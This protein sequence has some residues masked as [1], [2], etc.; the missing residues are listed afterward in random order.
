MPSTFL[1]PGSLS[2]MY[3]FLFISCFFKSHSDSNYLFPLGESGGGENMILKSYV[4]LGN[5]DPERQ[6]S[7]VLF[8]TK[9]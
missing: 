4:E 3:H 5:T 7:H 6:L 1:E 8:H 2:S 9:F